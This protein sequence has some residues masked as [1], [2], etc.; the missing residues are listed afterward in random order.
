MTDAETKIQISDEH[1]RLVQNILRA[2]LPPAA[3]AFVFGSRAKGEAWKFS[4][5]DLAVA[6][7]AEKL[8]TSTHAQLAWAFAESLLPYKVDVVDFNGC[9]EQF[10]AA[11]RGDCRRLG[12]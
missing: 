8:S 4:D 7:G 1:L 9:S 12:W 2:H 3:T 6:C 11:I 5:L 10:R